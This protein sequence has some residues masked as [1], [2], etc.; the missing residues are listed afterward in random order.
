MG[1][2]RG[3]CWK[4]HQKMYKVVKEKSSYFHGWHGGFFEVTWNQK[5]KFG[6]SINNSKDGTIL[7]L[8]LATIYL[9]Q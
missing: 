9:Y 8:A 3:P 2:N 7:K 1:L 4:G 6:Q 5:N